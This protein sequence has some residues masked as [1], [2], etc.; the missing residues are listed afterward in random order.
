MSVQGQKLTWWR[1]TRMSAKC[2]ERKS[3]PGNL[4]LVAAL[5]EA[6]AKRTISKYQ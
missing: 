2:Q 1:R 6:Y 3:K 4:N 5:R